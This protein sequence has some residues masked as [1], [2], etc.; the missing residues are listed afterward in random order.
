MSAPIQ[1]LDVRRV[2]NLG[3]VRAYVTIRI[4]GVTIHGAK[5]VQKPNQRPWLAMPDRQWTG[6]DGKQHYS[7]LVELS[8]SLKARVSEAVLADWQTAEPAA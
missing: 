2:D 3:N 8:P 6:A 4:G 7:A 1:V 5:I